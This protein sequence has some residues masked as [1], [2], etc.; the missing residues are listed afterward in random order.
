MRM[1]FQ[2][3]MDKM[4]IGLGTALALAPTLASAQVTGV[5][6]DSA[7][8]DTAI[9]AVVSTA[10]ASLSN[11]WVVLGYILG[12]MVC[13]AIVALVGRWFKGMIVGR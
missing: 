7:D 10:S 2:K 6:I 3:H 4:L 13:F 11:N 8:L 9:N 1:K 12:G 5:T